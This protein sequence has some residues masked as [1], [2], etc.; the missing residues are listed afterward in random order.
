MSGL[1][2]IFFAT[3]ATG[4]LRRPSCRR[5]SRPST[6]IR[7]DRL[8]NPVLHRPHARCGLGVRSSKCVPRC[9]CHGR[10]LLRDLARRHRLGGGGL[11][12]T[13]ARECRTLPFW[14]TGGPNVTETFAR[15]EELT[16]VDNSAFSLPSPDFGTAETRRLPATTSP[17]RATPQTDQTIAIYF[18]Q[19]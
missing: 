13:V 1:E 5:S 9:R 4:E 2:P 8:L 7:L 14:L 15:R 18:E 10:A 16:N 6:I 12:Q 17:C 11:V 19:P 3:R